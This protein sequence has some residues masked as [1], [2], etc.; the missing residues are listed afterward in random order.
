M[1]AATALA[2]LIDQHP[3]QLSLHELARILGNG[4]DDW[5]QQDEVR[6]ALHQLVADGLAQQHGAFYSR[7]MPRSDP[8]VEFAC[9]TSVTAGVGSKAEPRSD[10][11][12]I[13]TRASVSLL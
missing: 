11:P 9:A 10:P 1:L 5:N 3:A 8:G 4:T 12:Q 7:R 6:V 13:L 2:I